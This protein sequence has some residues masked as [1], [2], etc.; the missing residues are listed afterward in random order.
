MG[1]WMAPSYTNLFMGRF[2][3]QFRQTQNKLPLVWWRYIDDVFAIWT[4][5]VPSL[6]V[7]LRELNN[8]HT[9]IKFTADWSA[10]E[11]TFLDTWVYI[12]TGR[13][14][15]DLHV[16]L[17]SK[18][19]H[20]HTKSCHPK[21]C[22]TV[23]Q[24]S[25][26]LRIKTICSEW[27]NLLLRTD[28]LRH[29]LSKRGYSDQ[30][31]DSEIN[32]A[33]NTSYGSSSSRSNRL[34]S[35]RVPLVVT[36][37]PNLPKFERTIRRYHHILQDLDW[38][39]KAFPFLPI[40]AFRSPRNLHNVLVCANITSKISDPP[41]NFCC[42]SRRC[43]TCPIL[44]TTEAFSS[45]VTGERFKLKLRAYC[46]TSNVI[47]LIQCRR[48][49]LQYVG[50]TGNPS[51]FKLTAIVSTSPIVAQTNPLCQPILPARAIP[52]PI[53]RSWSSTNAGRMTFPKIRKSRWIRSLNTSWPS[54][55]NL[56]TNGL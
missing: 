45:S 40:I 25:Q 19:Q 52:W 46:K 56:R 16:K 2:E 43:K 49:S 6:N 29:H 48:C 21:Y 30:S 54:G 31:L 3:Q 26:A 18:H 23:V 1:S 27:E 20:L 22:K 5:G 38:L 12:K 55:M 17:T 8:Y 51:A 14:E 42:K 11:V 36:Y 10:Q 9:T 35:N 28:Q 34:N 50:E 4:H 13:V 47:Y 37:H 39:W 24:Y 33:I 41:G 15:T 7:F 44:V 32:Q 53:Y